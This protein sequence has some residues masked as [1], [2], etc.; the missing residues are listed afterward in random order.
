MTET[1]IVDAFGPWLPADEIAAEA[2]RECRV[3][4][5]IVQVQSVLE[6]NF[7][8]TA[9]QALPYDVVDAMRTRHSIDLTGF[10]L[11]MTNTRKADLI[12]DLAA[13]CDS[14]AGRQRICSDVMAAWS[15]RELR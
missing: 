10:N 3:P 9:D 2:L 8:L 1:Q 5:P 6:A 13:E 14:P 7:D 15:M 12:A 11:S 4:D